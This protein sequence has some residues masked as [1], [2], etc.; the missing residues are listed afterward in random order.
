MV[1]L[2]PFPVPGGN[3]TSPP[4]ADLLSVYYAPGTILNFWFFGFLGLVGWFGFGFACIYASHKVWDVILFMGEETM[5]WRRR[6]SWPAR[7]GVTK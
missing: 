7:A 5:V 4:G 1:A 2:P 3:A 6:A